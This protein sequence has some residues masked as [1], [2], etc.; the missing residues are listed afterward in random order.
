MDMPRRFV[1]VGLLAAA[2]VVGL[3]APPA[4]GLGAATL[5][6]VAPEVP[7]AEQPTGE[8]YFDADGVRIRYLDRGSGEPVVLLHGFSLSAEMNWG[9]TG[10]LA[11]IPREFRLIAVDLR[12]HGRSGK[13]SGPESY[14]RELMN[15]VV[16][17]L[18][19]LGIEQATLVGYSM[20]GAIALKLLTEQPERIRAAV[21]GGSGWRPPGT[22]PPAFLLGWVDGLDA[23]AE[24]SGSV[25]EV[26]WRPGWPDPTP[27]MRAGLDANDAGALAAVL[28]SLGELPVSEEALRQSEVPVLAVVGE[29]DFVLPEVE[30][31]RAV[32]P[33]VSVVMLPGSNHATALFDP[34][35]EA[36][37]LRFLRGHEGR[38][39]DPQPAGSGGSPR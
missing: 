36:A 7:A 10:L 12:G 8:R 23:V 37:V 31:L 27:E 16:R 19:H 11:S 35:L 15:D 13:P 9:P 24:G 22:P 38:R 39:T 30:A 5:Q 17:L 26:L 32:R 20:G 25:T 21:L 18:D 14:G 2:P 28:R 29:E 3:G 1:R 6:E 34:G 4:V 33:D